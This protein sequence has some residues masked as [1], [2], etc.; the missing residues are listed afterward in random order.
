MVIK[1]RLKNFAIMTGMALATAASLYILPGCGT[2]DHSV[3]AEETV[4]VLNGDSEH[5]PSATIDF[6]SIRSCPREGDVIDFFASASSNKQGDNLFMTRFYSEPDSSIVEKVHFNVNMQEIYEDSIQHFLS[7]GRKTI[8]YS[9]ITYE[10][11]TALVKKELDVCVNLTPYVA[12]VDTDKDGLADAS[13]ANF[14]SLPSGDIILIGGDTIYIPKGRNTEI[15]VVCI[16][17][18]KDYT[19]VMSLDPLELPKNISLSDEGVLSIDLTSILALPSKIGVTCLDWH[20][21]PLMY[22]RLEPY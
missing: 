8:E 12:G 7:P 17:P 20:Q 18:D 19:P 4:D 16:D 13:A 21:A 2:E 11:R 10:G 6:A 3:P 22:I 15:K 1:N 14:N 5:A 9:L